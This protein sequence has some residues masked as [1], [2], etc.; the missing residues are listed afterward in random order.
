MDV[1][2][3]DC[4]ASIGADQQFCRSC[5]SALTADAL[6]LMLPQTVTLISV[7]LV[8]LGVLVGVTGGMVE[9]RWL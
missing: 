6:P 8:F 1:H 3:S 5:G 7:L 4:G 2:C 9:L